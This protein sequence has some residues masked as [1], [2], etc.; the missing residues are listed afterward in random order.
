MQ[1]KMVKFENKLQED[2]RNLTI[3][4]IFNSVIFE[5]QIVFSD[6]APL[7]NSHMK[8]LLYEITR[9]SNLEQIAIAIDGIST[10]K[11]HALVAAKNG[12][13]IAAP[14]QVST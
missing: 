6:T 7:L 11:L 12:T 1:N 13:S 4:G 3:C 2:L 9:A 10:K 14:G 8:H 5:V